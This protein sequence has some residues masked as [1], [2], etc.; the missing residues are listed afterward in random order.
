MMRSVMSES[1]E[2]L[3]RIADPYMASARNV[4]DSVFFQNLVRVSLERRTP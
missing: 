3:A 2:I 1:E 4:F